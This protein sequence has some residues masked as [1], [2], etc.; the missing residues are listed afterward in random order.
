M[1]TLGNLIWL[2]FGGIIAAFL[3]II[4]GLLLCVTIIGIPFGVQCFKIAEF[5]LWPFGREIYPG[6]FGIMGFLGNI[7]W[8]LVLG[9]ELC[10]AHLLIG[11]VF[12]ITIVGIPFGL[13]HFKL[14][15]LALIP[16][17]AE[18]RRL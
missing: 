11:L 15:K 7:I 9:I 13:Q 12:C 2:I 8:I 1:K 10:I 6:N 3:W 17:G 16:F 14:A 18:I 4:A 5:V